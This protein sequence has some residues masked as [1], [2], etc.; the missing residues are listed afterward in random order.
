MR[1]RIAIGTLVGFAALAAGRVGGAP[2]VPQPARESNRLDIP[3]ACTPGATVD[4]DADGIP[5]SVEVTE[6]T[7]PCVMDNDVFARTRLFAM[8]QYRDFLGREGDSFGIGYWSALTGGGTSRAAVTRSFFDSPEFQGAIAPVTRLYFAYFNRIPDKPGIDYWIGQYRLG[9]PLNDISQAFAESPEFSAT[10]GGLDNAA[11][12][13]LVYNNVLGRA[14]D[15]PGLAYWTGQLSGGLLTRGRVMLGFSESPE[16]RQSSYNRVFVT[17]VYYGMLRRVPEQVGFDY[18]V[19]QL[20][21]GASGFNL[22][23]G[24]FVAPE[25]YG[26]FLPAGFS[27]ASLIN[28]DVAADVPAAELEFVRSGIDNGRAYLAASVG[29]DI[30]GDELSRLTVRVV[31]TG[32]G[33]PSPG[34]FGGG[35]TALDD[36]G[37]ARIFLD[38]LHA[39]WNQNPQYQYSAGH[40]LRTAAHEYTHAWQNR[41]GCN[42][43]LSPGATYTHLEGWMTEGEAEFVGLQTLIP[44]RLDSD[45]ARKWSLNN[46]VTDGQ[47]AQSLATLEYIGLPY[48]IW[49]GNIGYLAIE[50][51]TNRAPGGVLSLRTHCEAL[52]QGVERDQAFLTAFGISKAS[53]YAAFPTYIAQLRALYGI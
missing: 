46:A 48:G 41:T 31:A 4:T 22:I 10:Y 14:P 7:N 30:P 47:A 23:N 13:T 19:T 36:N 37:V 12:V 21:A 6:G 27:H 49:P 33:N 16:Y 17:M 2:T 45:T 44:S 42:G 24:F 52:A 34:A 20:N 1:D 9:L 43:R 18:W 51:L 26:R 28:Y 8:Q 53:Y 50:D 25:Y 3:A 35:C 5:D 29:G 15:A 32:L 11:F 40:K 38:V 39:C